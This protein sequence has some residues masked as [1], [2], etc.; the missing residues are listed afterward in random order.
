MLGY[1][2]LLFVGSLLVV[3]SEIKVIEMKITKAIKGKRK[4]VWNNPEIADTV[5]KHMKGI[6]FRKKVEKPVL[7]VFDR[8]APVSIHSFFC[9]PFDIIYINKFGKVLKT[10]GDVAPNTL[11][12]AVRCKYIIECKPGEIK[13]KRIKTGDVLSF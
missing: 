3:M 5:G 13:K 2:N 9:A 4:V 1:L 11:L 6:M 8:E 10:S 7:F 12:P